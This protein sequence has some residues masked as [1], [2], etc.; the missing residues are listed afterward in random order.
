MPCRS[1]HIHASLGLFCMSLLVNQRRLFAGGA[2]E[3]EQTVGSA[4]AL[5]GATDQLT[6]PP[7]A[8]GAEQQRQHAWTMQHVRPPRS[9]A[10]C[11]ARC[12]TTRRCVSSVSSCQHNR[13]GVA[14]PL[15]SHADVPEALPS[16]GYR[17][18]RRRA[19][20][21]REAVPRVREVLTLDVHCVCSAAGFVQ[22]FVS[23]SSFC[24]A[25]YID[26]IH[27]SLM[28]D[29]GCNVPS[30]QQCS[31]SFVMLGCHHCSQSL[32]RGYDVARCGLVEPLS[33]SP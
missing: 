33:T 20:A 3:A 16:T 14:G 6:Q 18:Q 32:S 23:T 26:I 22:V 29:K 25:V 27:D 11:C 12:S 1:L 24:V 31:S 10:A 30:Q 28:L 9:V 2:E 17:W 7:N 13:A 4:P 8:A 19:D 21:A 15:A 5:G